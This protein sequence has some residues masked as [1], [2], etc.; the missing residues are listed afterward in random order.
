MKRIGQKGEGKG[1]VKK[2]REGVKKE[3]E[4]RENDR[5]RMKLICDQFKSE[6]RFI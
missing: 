6:M 4:G 2:G 5:E 1:R 3:R